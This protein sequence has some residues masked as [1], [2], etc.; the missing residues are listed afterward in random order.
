MELIDRAKKPKQQLPKKIQTDVSL[1]SKNKFLDA[2]EK[3][4]ELKDKPNIEN[5][6]A[7]VKDHFI[8]IEKNFLNIQNT[9]HQEFT[10][11][12]NMLNVYQ[13]TITAIKTNCVKLVI[14][15]L[16]KLDTQESSENK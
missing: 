16:K 11:Y 3:S 7:N 12:G 14:D 1:D 8:L 2:I 13:L 10:Q 4:T 6:S 9:I 15:R 5:I